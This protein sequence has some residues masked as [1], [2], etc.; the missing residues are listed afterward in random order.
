MREQCLAPD[1]ST[2]LQTALAVE[3]HLEEGQLLTEEQILNKE[4][5]LIY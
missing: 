1:T 5:S 3:A 2:S 4:M